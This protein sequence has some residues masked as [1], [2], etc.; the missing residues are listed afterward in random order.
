MTIQDALQ[1]LM[2]V[3]G[4]LGSAVFLPTGEPLATHAIGANLNMA[5]V[6]VLANNALL[7]AQK[8]ALEMGA[9]RGQMIHIMGE[10]EHILARCVNEGKDPVKSEPGK[11][12]YHTIL[13]LANDNAIGMAKLRLNQ[14]AESMAPELRS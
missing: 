1:Q 10:N 6:G 9:G 8:A 13:V 11:A 3:E 12:H 4:Y 14:V 5:Q 2:Q 7:N